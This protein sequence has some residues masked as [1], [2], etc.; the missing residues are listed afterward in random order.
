MKRI[1]G[2]FFSV[3][4]ALSIQSCGGPT[5]D[6]TPNKPQK[7]V[8]QDPADRSGVTIEKSVQ[9]TAVT[10]STVKHELTG[11]EWLFI[12]ISLV[13]AGSIVWLLIRCNKYKSQFDE[14]NRR[15]YSY[16]SRMDHR[17]REIDEL[18][19]KLDQL[20]RDLSTLS[21]KRPS[22]QPNGQQKVQSPLVNN[23]K[24]D[25]VKP[26]VDITATQPIQQDSEF[27]FL[28]HDG[29][30]ILRVVSSKEQ[31]C[32]Q[33]EFSKGQNEGR[34]EFVGNVGKAIKNRSAILDDVCEMESFDGNATSIHTDSWGTCIR[35]A[36]GTWK[37]T[38]KAKISFK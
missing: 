22:N 14:Y 30:G 7:E 37:V 13:E 38:K 24:D 20:K 11:P 29:N 8:V 9:S 34:F 16:E 19:S 31:A 27:L 2:I 1:I 3:V 32:Y 33:V 21:S 6:N 25:I 28:D 15:M 18:Q 35:Q 10:A 4:V 17:K 5:N 26:P 23:K 12:L 36:D